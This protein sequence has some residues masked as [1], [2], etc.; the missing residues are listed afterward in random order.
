MNS[1]GLSE[2]LRRPLAPLDALPARAPAHSS[3]TTLPDSPCACGGGCPS[4]G[5]T[6]PA[7]A[8]MRT[9][10][11][12]PV[13]AKLTVGEDNHPSERAADSAAEHVVHGRPGPPQEAR[14]ADT[15]PSSQVAA[16][17]SVEQALTRDGTAMPTAL[18]SDM[19]GRFGRDFS[20]VRIL[21]DPASAQSAHDVHAR[22]YTVGHRII[23]GEGQF[24]PSST[25]GRQLLAHELAHVVQQS[26]S[27]KA[28]ADTLR[29]TPAPPQI[30][31]DDAPFDRGIVNIPPIADIDGS[32]PAPGK[33]AVVAKSVPV[34]FSDPSIVSLRWEFFDPADAVLPGG[35]A[36]VKAAAKATTAPLVISNAPARAWTPTAGR[37]LVR[38]TGLD[39]TGAAVAYA[40]RT[41][42]LWTTKPTGKAPDIVTLTAEKARLDAIVKKGS[43]KSLGEV[44]AATTQLKD[45]THD[46]SILETGTG[47]YVGNQCPV[48]PAGATKTDCTNIVLE[49]LSGVFAQQGRTADWDK[50][51]KKY[52]ENTALRGGTG[53]SGLDVQ[54]ALQSEAG[55]K[56]VYWAPDPKY[57][58]PKAE[59][60]KANSDEAS[61]TS[62]RAAKNKSYY[63]NF[64]KTGYPGVSIDQSVTN[65]AP[66]VPTTPTATEPVSV[67]TKTTAQLDKLKKV[68]FGVLAAHGGEHMTIISYGKVTE[69]H[70]RK[71][72]TDRDLIEQTD[73]EN[74]AVGPLSG[75]HYYA[76]GSIVA[77]ADDIAAAFL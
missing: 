14:H 13:Q 21:S 60:D 11:R 50:I 36:T 59:L 64:G 12:E 3:T 19:A 68:P 33:P 38:C 34:T 28:P 27:G 22:A 47:T 15:S 67:T 62:T 48:L 6:T 18:Q 71:E 25:G 52:A 72:A 29:R 10:G 7:S 24:A 76:S 8:Q 53:L 70:W 9:S 69:V 77:P 49:V 20:G 23:F 75:F 58:I 2:K 57:Q 26:D 51:K 45:V 31:T 66:E 32:P 63:K 44:G 61:F 54:A 5:A 73:L 43:G 74:W 4:C 37:H 65:Y 40:D 16:P 56:G 1:P 17:K 55:W 39:T 46:L 35:F 30:G 42:W 41:F